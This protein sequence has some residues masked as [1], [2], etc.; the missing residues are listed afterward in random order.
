MRRRLIGV[1]KT[2]YGA[3]DVVLTDTGTSA[4]R[5]AIQGAFRGQGLVG[6]P[7]YACF[8]LASAAEGAGARVALY[9]VDPA[10]LGP[11]PA[12][13]ASVAELRPD[14]LVVAHLFGYAVDVDLVTRAAGGALVIEDAA[15][16]AGGT[17]RG[18]LLGS[19]GSVSVLSFGRGK[20]MTGGGGGALLA[21]DDRGL[22]VL[23]R[24][25]GEIGSRGERGGL[26]VAALLSQLVLG[27]PSLYGIPA[28]MPFL[29][30]GETRYH[31]PQRP[32]PA[33]DA[34]LAVLERVIDVSDEEVRVRRAT[35]DRL[36]RALVGS[37]RFDAVEPVAG[38]ASGY[39]RLAVRARAADA[40][41]AV[42]PV[43]RLGIVS[44]YPSTLATLPS[45]VP[46]L[47]EPEP[48]LPGATALVETLVSVPTHRLLREREIRTIERWLQNE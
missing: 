26:R 40:V 29:H 12:S 8:D 11:D 36:A 44:M 37:A 48:R 46:R 5:L 20:G 47:V 32:A 10:T 23:D 34:C 22:G 27:R 9:D 43:K 3:L 19:F 30:L 25:R 18:R 6:L 4:L 41:A 38:A 28:S 39:L 2:R 14:A 13:L 1:L 17:L 31:P 7:G 24:A 35:A 16:G 42:R 21:H 15:Q 45:L 33:A